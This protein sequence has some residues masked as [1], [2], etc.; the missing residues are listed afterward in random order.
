MRALRSAFLTGLLASLMILLAEAQGQERL[1]N[2]QDADRIFRMTRSQWEAEAKQMVHPGGWKVRLGPVD[3]G[4]VVMAFD[5][6]TG[7]GLSI[8]PLFRDAQGPPDMLVVG[9]YYPP[10]KFGE[11]S[12]QRKRE[13]EAAARS[14][15]GPAYSVRIS[16]SKM[17][18]PAPGFDVVEVIITRAPAL[19]GPQ[20]IPEKLEQ[21]YFDT[22]D[23]WVARGGP[24][25]EVQQTVVQTCGKL[26]MLMASAAEKMAL[27]TARREDFHFRVAVCTKIT[28]N[29]VHPQPE[30]EKR[31]TVAIICD[32]SEIDL[33]K[34]LCK[35]SKL[36]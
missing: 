13:M 31:E 28:V 36:R 18:S 29:R 6:K 15:L 4:T 11:L 7:V 10:G 30:F 33:F 19:G 24:M 35:W 5:P 14:D 22:L 17:S 9:S 23:A 12:E 16:F 34:T 25:D 21:R 27:A 20:T 1:V 3:T 8:Q 2:K 32:R 26:V